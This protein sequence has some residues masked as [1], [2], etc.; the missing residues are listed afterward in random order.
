M[1]TS[2]GY[3]IVEVMMVLLI[4]GVLITVGA[5]GIQDFL[6]NNAR[7]GATNEMV[8]AIQQARS[9]AIKRNQRTAV[10]PVNAGADGCEA[11]TSWEGGFLAFVDTDGDMIRD[12]GEEILT[13]TTPLGGPI[14]LRST[15]QAFSYIPNGRMITGAGDTQAELVLCDDRGVDEGRYILIFASGRPEISATDLANAALA[16]CTP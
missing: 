15:F 2:A 11:T 6:K 14:T 10:C 5:P 1:K 3:T 13:S 16:D 4:A 12:A 8:A 7:A 9:E